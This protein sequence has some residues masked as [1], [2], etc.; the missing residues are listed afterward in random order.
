MEYEA[1]GDTNSDLKSWN[2]FQEPER[3][4][5]QA[6][7]Q[8]HQDHSTVGFLESPGDSLSLRLQ[9]PPTS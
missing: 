7:N 2:S 3:T 5:D 6:K 8:K 1:D 4:R 9:C